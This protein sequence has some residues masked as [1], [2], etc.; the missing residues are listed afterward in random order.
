MASSAGECVTSR[1][2]ILLSWRTINVRDK[3]VRTLTS[4]EPSSIDRTES[5]ESCLE[6]SG[7][8]RGDG[9]GNGGL[10]GKRERR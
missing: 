6:H 1:W 3:L 9:G 8:V 2:E 5:Q 4:E 7:K 10:R